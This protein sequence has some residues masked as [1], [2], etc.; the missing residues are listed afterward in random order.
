MRF[1]E[2]IDKYGIPV[3][4]F[5]RR[6]KLGYGTCINIYAGKCRNLQVSSAEKIIDYTEGQITLKDLC[7]DVREST[8][9]KERL[10]RQ[11]KLQE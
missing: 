6:V 2:Y 10:H 4:E 9:I 11:G 7:Q 3:A 8:H 5:A 1:R